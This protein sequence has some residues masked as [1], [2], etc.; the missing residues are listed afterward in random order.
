MRSSN[1]TPLRSLCILA[2]LMIQALCMGSMDSCRCTTA[3]PHCTTAHADA[4]HH[5]HAC[6]E[7]C[8]A[9]HTACAGGDCCHHSGDC[10]FFPAKN[11][12]SISQASNVTAPLF[13]PVGIILLPKFILETDRRREALLSLRQFAEKQIK[14]LS[15]A[16]A[17]STVLIV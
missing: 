15:L 17:R 7:S 12:V 9:G 3:H 10:D 4:H 13:V 14:P 1:H 2:V 16:L 11:P 5:H 6:N 8:P